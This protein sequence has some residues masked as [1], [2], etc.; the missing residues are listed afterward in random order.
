MLPQN[1]SRDPT[2][3]VP[4]KKAVV[5][6]PKKAPQAMKDAMKAWA[7]NHGAKFHAN[8]GRGFKKK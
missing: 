8:A 5:V 7:A 4:Q 1:F 6:A 2:R 3:L